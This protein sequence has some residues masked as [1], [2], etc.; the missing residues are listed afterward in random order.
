MSPSYHQG[1]QLQLPTPIGDARDSTTNNG[2]LKPRDPHQ[3]IGRE[4][5]QVPVYSWPQEMRIHEEGRDSRV[6]MDADINL[7][8]TP[9]LADVQAIRYLAEL[10]PAHQHRDVATKLARKIW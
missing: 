4:W 8:L 2:M 10:S 1:N 6:P 3:S 7:Y 9:C 5:V